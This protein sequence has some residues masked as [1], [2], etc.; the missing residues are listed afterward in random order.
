MEHEAFWLDA[1]DHSRLYV[2]A[3]RP[4]GN[5]RAVVM[6]SHGMAEHGGRYDRLGVA[7]MRAGFAL[8]AADQRGHGQTA[9]HGTLGHYA[10]QDGW[11]KV[12]GDLATLNQRR[13][14]CAI[15]ACRFSCSV[16]AWAVTSPR[17]IC[18]TT[19]PVCRGRFSAA[20][21]SIRSRSTALRR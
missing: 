13:S 5:A 4:M 11:N 17:G 15:R 2:R 18:C 12:V 1:Q 6:L 14:Q 7:L 8:Y 21:I 9:S 16:T 20:R 19:A 3:W 10:D